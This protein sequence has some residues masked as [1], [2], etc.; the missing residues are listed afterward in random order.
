MQ[1]MLQLSQKQEVLKNQS[2]SL[3]PNSQQFKEIAQQQQN[4]QVDL[5]NIANAMAELLARQVADIPGVELHRSPQAN[6]VF[7][8][9]PA[10]SLEPL[11]AWSPFYVWDQEQDLVRW[12]CSYDTT[13]KDVGVFSSGIAQI[14]AGGDRT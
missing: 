10:W 12:V 11:I 3:D 6:A 5:N 8:T 13:E 4:L 2:R 7:A 1:E 14:L 9:L